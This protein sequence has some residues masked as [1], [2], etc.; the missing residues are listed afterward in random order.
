MTL[1]PGVQLIFK[2][3][4]LFSKAGLLKLLG[5]ISPFQGMLTSGT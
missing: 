5:R 3:M 2:I 1:I 4:V